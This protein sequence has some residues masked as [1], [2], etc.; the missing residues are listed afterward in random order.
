MSNNKDENIDVL[1][2]G[3]WSKAFIAL[4]QRSPAELEKAKR[5][6]RWMSMIL[7]NTK[8]GESLKGK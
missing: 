3:D 7:P 8:I 2:Q 4:N 1:M 6:F 5:R